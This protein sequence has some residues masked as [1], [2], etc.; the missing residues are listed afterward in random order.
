MTVLGPDDP[1]ARCDAVTPEELDVVAALSALAD[2]VKAFCAAALTTRP[3][4]ERWLDIADELRE[5]AGA[6]Q[7]RAVLEP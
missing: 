7:R 4:G 6:C 2:R 3:P 5:G 1:R